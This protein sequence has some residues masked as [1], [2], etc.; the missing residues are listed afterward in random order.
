MRRVTEVPEVTEPPPALPAPSPRVERAIVLALV[1]LSAVLALRH[2]SGD[3]ATADE[4][5]HVAAAVEIAREGTGRWNPE[6]PPLAKALAG[7]ALTGL[8]L[9]PAEDPLRTPAGPARLLRFLFANET[10][11]ET[12]LFRARLPFVALLAALLLA[13]RGEARR[14][15]GPWAGVAALAFAA[16]EPN[17]NAHAGVVHTDLAVTL[18]V[19][20]SLSPLARLARP[21][22]GRAAPL[23]GL[24]W[25]LAFLSKYSAPLLALATLPFLAADTTP[26]RQDLGRLLRRLAAAAAIALAVTLAGFAWACRG[27]SAEDRRA[28]AVERLELKG[29]SPAAA[30]LAVRAGDLLP[31]LGNV[32]TGALSVALQ[33]EV[34]AGVNY[35]LGAVSREG[36]PWYF[37]VALAVKTPLGLLLG[38]GVALSAR[39]GRRTAAAAGASLL[40]FLL[41][42]SRTTYNIGVR[43]ALI[44]FP[45]LAIVAGAAASGLTDLSARRSA[46]LRLG[47]TLGALLAASL[48]AA[49]AHPHPF[50]FFNA[51]AGGP[52][53]G[54]RFFADSSLDWGQDLLRLKALAPS[55]APDGLPT[56]AFGGDLPSR[57][58]PA[59]RPPAPGEEDRPGAVFAIGEAPFALGPEL[60]R[61]KGATGDAERLESIRTALRER[62]RRI[63]TVGGSIGLWRIESPPARRE[64]ARAS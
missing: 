14:R 61:A 51:L 54:R 45:L 4:P 16:L 49:T 35:F 10:P 8:P 3:A 63:G 19:V 33:S 21:E 34:G 28:I 13:V 37:P 2:L 7:L 39:A 25:G 11:A 53:G 62:G 38:V 64:P 26:G 27:Q 5:V 22:A 60:L 50:S 29:R 58:A 48:E 52:D 36:S 55:L 9:R 30:C 42:S 20:L 41:F 1:V 32:L 56:V 31:P 59:L 57:H 17:L 18:F 6:H 23:L 43:H 47:A 46:R 44:A 15:W 24:L 40:L 12:I